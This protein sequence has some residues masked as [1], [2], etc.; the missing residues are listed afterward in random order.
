MPQLSKRL[1]D[2]GMWHHYSEGHGENPCSLAYLL[3]SIFKHKMTNVYW[4]V[5]K[6]LHEHELLCA[7]TINWYLISGIPGE[8][9][10]LSFSNS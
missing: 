3:P 6:G 5:G 4:Y 9:D 10:S 2:E 8:I 1:R 7:P